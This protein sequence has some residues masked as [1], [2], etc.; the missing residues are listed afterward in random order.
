MTFQGA[1]HLQTLGALTDY[2]R[3]KEEAERN[4]PWERWKGEYSWHSARLVRR[5]AT[6]YRWFL[7]QLVVVR[8]D[9]RTRLGYVT[10][11]AFNGPGDFEMSLMLY[12]GAPRSVAVRPTSIA[13]AEEPPLPV[14]MLNATDDEPATLIVPPRTFNAG[15]LLRSMVA[16]PERTY[17]LTKLLQRGGDFERVAFEES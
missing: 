2:D 5:E 14:L 17:R 11:V 13:F 4:W 15:R 10:R 3:H 8:D 12:A 6:R 7:D 16:G 9:E 1:Q